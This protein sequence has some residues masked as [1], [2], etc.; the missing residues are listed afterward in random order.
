MVPL[1]VPSRGLQGFLHVFRESL[2]FRLS[3]KE[4]GSTVGAERGFAWLDK[5][6]FEQTEVQF[7]Q[8]IERLF[9]AAEQEL[10]TAT[11]SVHRLSTV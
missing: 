4:L 2:D 3:Q 11:R 9:M 6:L 10:I 5:K 1:N 7:S 8:H